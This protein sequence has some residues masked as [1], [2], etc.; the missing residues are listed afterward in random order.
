MTIILWE[1]NKQTHTTL[2]NAFL[3]VGYTTLGTFIEFWLASPFN[4]LSKC[5]NH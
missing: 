2:D 4:Y 3:L 1:A 5:L